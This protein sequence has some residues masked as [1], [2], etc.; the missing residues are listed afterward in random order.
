MQKI[1]G[2]WFPI[3]WIFLLKK[4]ILSNLISFIL[5]LFSNN[6]FNSDSNVGSN[7]KVFVVFTVSIFVSFIATTYSPREYGLFRSLVGPDVEK[8]DMFEN[9]SFYK[10]ISDMDEFLNKEVQ[11]TIKEEPMKNN[12]SS[13]GLKQIVLYVVVLCTGIGILVLIRKL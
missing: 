4:D 6:F 7:I 3:L 10:D 9:L 5:F 1:R 8:N 2:I 11:Q 13:I 12:D